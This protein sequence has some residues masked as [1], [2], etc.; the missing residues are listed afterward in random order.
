MDFRN[1][2][3][4][5]CSKVIKRQEVHD[6]FIVILQILRARMMVDL[7]TESMIFNS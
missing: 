3:A 5:P 4:I 6:E 1:R 7:S 2:C